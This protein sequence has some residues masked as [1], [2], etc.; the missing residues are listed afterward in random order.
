MV[1]T[2]QVMSWTWKEASSIYPNLMGWVSPRAVWWLHW[3]TLVVF[4]PCRETGGLHYHV[5]PEE[6]PDCLGLHWPREE[7]LDISTLVCTKLRIS[8]VTSPRQ[9]SLIKGPLFSKKFGHGLQCLLF[10]HSVSSLSLVL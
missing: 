3:Q 4:S 5:L 6:L 10:P 8:P 2:W 9:C 1:W 7:P